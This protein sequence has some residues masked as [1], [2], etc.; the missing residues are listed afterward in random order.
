MCIVRL[1]QY[2]CIAQRFSRATHI[3]SDTS[4]AAGGS[5]QHVVGQALHR[6]GIHRDVKGVHQFMD[7]RLRTEA[8]DLRR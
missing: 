7:V 6:G 2:T 4:Y 1:H 5:L 3:G 8:D